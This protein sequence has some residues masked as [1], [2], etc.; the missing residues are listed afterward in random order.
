[1]QDWIL[2]E[3][4]GAEFGDERLKK[5][6]QLLLDR[7]ACAPDASI[8]SACKGA[9][10]VVG[11][12]RFLNN[13]QV[14]VPSI[15][16]PH[17]DA[18]LE[19][20]KAC[21]RVLLVQDTT[22]L[23]YSTKT[24][25]QGKG[26][27]SYENRTGFFA[28]NQLVITP[29][30]LTLGVWNTDIYARDVAEQGKSKK[31][32]QRAF[33]DKESYRW[34]EGYRSGCEL[35]QKAPGVQVIVCGDRESDVYEVFEDWHRRREAKE[36]A[37]A[38]WLIRCKEN[39]RLQPTGQGQED[40]DGTLIRT[41]RDKLE[42]SP[43][44][45]TITIHVKKKIQCKNKRKNR[46][47]T[48]RSARN[49][50]LDIHYAPIAPRPPYRR[51]RK[52]AEV[53]FY[54]VMARE[55]DPPEGEDPIEWILLTSMPVKDYQSAVDIVALYSDRWEIEVFHRTL[56]TGCRV[57][58]LQLK[59]DEPTKNAVALFMIVAWR[60]LYVMK[61]G[62]ECPELPC[63]AVFEA[64]EWQAFWVIVHDGRQDALVN[65]PSLGEFVRKVA[66][67]GGFLGRKHDGHPGPQA[68][69]QGM[70][71]VRH[72]TI[73]WQVYVKQQGYKAYQ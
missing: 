72:Y 46:K 17:R 71:K 56:K 14:D 1:M 48:L 5:R 7:C 60:V 10:E 4:A 26:P 49:A 42:A 23:D 40:D 62:R 55:V 2:E 32:K 44:M 47:K 15:L 54:A 53:S 51:E 38:D 33:E 34:L 66:E 20:V 36:P 30:R 45:G 16:K 25:L 43:T 69:W 13:K 67:Y 8:K 3:L 58:E 68:I 50:V 22:E 39:R 41:I 70:E 63:D 28:H 61:L 27:L 24:K 9:A 35:A 18:T 65:K 59:N 64:D 57:E 31:R 12:Y 37:I 73:A 11:A 19:R 6:M 21:S 29:E 52:L